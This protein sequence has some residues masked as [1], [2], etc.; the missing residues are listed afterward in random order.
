MICW[1]FFSLNKITFI[2]ICILIIFN[3]I[4]LINNI[5]NNCMIRNLLFII[6]KE[7]HIT[8]VGLTT[9]NMPVYVKVPAL[10]HKSK[11]LFKTVS[12]IWNKSLFLGD[13]VT[14]W[15]CLTNIRLK[16]NAIYKNMKNHNEDF[17]KTREK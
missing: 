4:L 10:S 15:T 12:V 13:H 9:D 14:F 2:Y 5:L 1:T 11:I 6:I 3:H 17:I 8:I 7:S 16:Q